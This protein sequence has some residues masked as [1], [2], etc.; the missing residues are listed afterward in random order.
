MAKTLLLGAALLMLAASPGRSAPV[1]RSTKPHD[2]LRWAYADTPE[3]VR[4]LVGR[5]VVAVPAVLIA[6]GVGVILRHALLSWLFGAIIV[7][8]T[9]NLIAGVVR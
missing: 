6:V 9:I 8:T 1:Q 4:V 7:A 3:G 2:P 5:A